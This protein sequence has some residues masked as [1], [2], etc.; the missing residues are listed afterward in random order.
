MVESDSRNQN[1]PIPRIMDY[2]GLNLFYIWLCMQ[3]I[4]PSSLNEN[5]YS[6]ELSLRIDWS[7]MDVL[8]HVN[9][10]MI[11]KYFQAGRINLWEQMGLNM[12]FENLRVEPIVASTSVQFF[13]PLYYPENIRVKTRVVEINNSS[14]SLEHILLNEKGETAAYEYDVIVNY[15]FEGEKSAPITDDF[16]LKLSQY[17]SR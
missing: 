13:R 3:R 4:D 15:D 7:E 17:Q 1:T 11:N 5:D 12:S 10:V 2:H 6:S 16:R 9:N 14:Y 8:N